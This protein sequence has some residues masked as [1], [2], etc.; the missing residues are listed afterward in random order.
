MTP[1]VPRSTERIYL[2][3]AADYVRELDLAA[4]LAHARRFARRHPAPML[5]IAA[6]AGFLIGRS[7][8]RE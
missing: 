8:A 7:L 1:F 5:L 6:A 2:S 3:A 4:I